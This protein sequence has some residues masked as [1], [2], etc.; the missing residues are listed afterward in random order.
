MLF[1]LSSFSPKSRRTTTPTTANNQN[2]SP[3]RLSGPNVSDDSEELVL[4]DDSLGEAEQ[5]HSAPVAELRRIV[6]L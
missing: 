1:T 6:P 2:Q 3:P 4:V 5:G